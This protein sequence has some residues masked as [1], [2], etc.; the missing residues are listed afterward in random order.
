MTIVDFKA[1]QFDIMFNKVASCN[2]MPFFGKIKRIAARSGTSVKN[3]AVRRKKTVYI[4]HGS[5]KL[6]D[7]TP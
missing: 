5:Q 1:Q 2:N 6:L 7:N 3:T 4:A